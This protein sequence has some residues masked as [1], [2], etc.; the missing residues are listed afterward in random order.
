MSNTEGKNGFIVLVLILLFVGV[1][2]NPTTPVQAIECDDGIDNNS[3]GVIDGQTSF[4]GISECHRSDPFFS[5]F[6]YCP[7]WISET[8]DI[9]T[10]MQN[11]NI[12]SFAIY[13]C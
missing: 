11:G 9:D 3:N 7:Q 13:G 1:L 10:E 2:S 5:G 4:G 12:T 6:I 8:I